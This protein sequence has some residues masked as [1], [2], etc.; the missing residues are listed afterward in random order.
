MQRRDL[1]KMI[2]AATGAAMVGGKAI[3]WDTTL[4]ATSAKDAG[5]TQDD[6]SLMSEIAETIIPRTN[7]P[8]AKDAKCA[9]MM[10]SF[11]ADCYTPDE[12]KVFRQGLL[13]I[14]AAS[15]AQHN[16]PFLLLDPSQRHALLSQIDEEAKQ[17]NHK[18]SAYR[19]ATSKPSERDINDD[20]PVPHYFTLFKQLTLYSF[21]TSRE[22]CTQV[23]RHVSIPTRYDG[24]LPYKKGD[25]AWAEIY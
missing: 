9:P 13:D 17:Y 14:D 4:T 22:G 6:L 1:L 20:G 8:G 21:F 24:D 19:S 11:V 23:L 3:A 7:T 10:A 2:A 18:M 5:F 15:K 16:L 12:Q 25:K